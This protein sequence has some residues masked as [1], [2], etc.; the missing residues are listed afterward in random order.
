MRAF[1]KLGDW[2]LGALLP[3]A[4]ADAA[5]CGSCQCAGSVC[6]YCRCGDMR[7]VDCGAGDSR[8]RTCHV[9]QHIC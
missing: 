3:S 2:M 5:G 8:C 9:T 7:W 4:A 6:G 1:A